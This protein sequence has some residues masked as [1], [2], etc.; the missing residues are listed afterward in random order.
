MSRGKAEEA[1]D[2]MDYLFRVN[3]GPR[4]EVNENEKDGA[5]IGRAHV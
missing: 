2:R 5:E 4:I 3:A 1:H